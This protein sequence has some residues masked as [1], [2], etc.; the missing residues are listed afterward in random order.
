MKQ[1]PLRKVSKKQ[2]KINRTQSE[3]KAEIIKEQ[4]KVLGYTFCQTCLRSLS[5]WQ[6][7]ASHVIAKSNGGATS[8]ANIVLEGNAFGCGCH[9]LYEKRPE[10]RPVGSIG[11][12]KWMAQ[13]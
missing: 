2:G 12:Q 4:R 1:T 8:E 11:Y 10:A 3:I 5:V 6:L 7:E 9:P 13:Q